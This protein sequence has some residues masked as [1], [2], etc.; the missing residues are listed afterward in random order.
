MNDGIYVSIKPDPIHKIVQGIKDHEFRNYV[1]KEDFKF[2]YV[3]V[4]APQS[5]LRYVIEIGKIV[6]YPD[7][8]EKNGDGNQEFNKGKKS[9]FAYSILKVYEL[10]NPIPLKEL[11]ER[12]SFVPPQAFSY[13]KTFQELTDYIEK[14]Q[15]VVIIGE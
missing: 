15:K 14:A 10:V 3:Y 2:L 8:L 13:S 11:K 5:E 1:P 7:K 4:S 12:F 6:Q 9:K